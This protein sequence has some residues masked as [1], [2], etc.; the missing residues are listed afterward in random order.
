M[1]DFQIENFEEEFLKEKRKLI[2]S[3]SNYV[4]HIG[5]VQTEKGMR[6]PLITVPNAEGR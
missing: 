2:D 3:L 1:I 5:V 4:I 6:S